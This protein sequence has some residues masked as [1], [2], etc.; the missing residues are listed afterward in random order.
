MPPEQ[1][2]RTMLSNLNPTE[3]QRA[4]IQTTRDTI[5][6]ALSNEPN[7]HLFSSEQ[8]SFLT[9][10]Y[11]RYTIIRP[12]DD[13]DLYVKIHYGMHAKDKPPR[14][15]L[16]LMAK[17]LRRRYIQTRIDVDSPCVV[18]KFQDYRFEVVPA[19]SYTD[20]EELFDIPGRGLE[21]WVSCYPHVP[22]KWLTSSNHY[23]NQKFIPLI[24]ILKQWNRANKVGL[25]SF[26]IELLT[27]MVFNNVSEITSY[28]QGV[29]D[30]MYFVS[31]WVHDNDSPF[32]LEPGESHTYVDQ[33]MYENKFKLY[34][35]RN[36]LESGLQKAQLAYYNWLQGKEARAEILWKQMF[37]D[38]FP[39]PNSTA[40]PRPVLPPGLI[41]GPRNHLPLASPWSK[42]SL[43][44]TNRLTPPPRLNSLFDLLSSIKDPYRK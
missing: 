34:M 15:I 41:P 11:S 28:P 29:N 22:N 2:F 33:Y 30:W 12:L 23:N 26:H 5:D 6:Q 36:K 14:G 24:K 31:K 16:I 27:G 37:G 44:G 21:S 25:K 8:P 38:M 35:T 4:A 3:K 32:V 39:A 19:V 40:T 42:P 7:I 10:S 18:I 43:F 1:S 17:A 9:G 20:N 13:I